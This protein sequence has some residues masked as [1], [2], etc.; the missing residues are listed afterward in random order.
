L[1]RDLL[2]L[3]ETVVNVDAAAVGISSKEWKSVSSNEAVNDVRNVMK[4]NHFDVIPITEGRAIKG[5]FKTST[6]NSYSSIRRHPI[7][8]RDIIPMRSHIAHVIKG[9]ASKDRR[10]YFLGHEHRVVGL[11]TVADL[12]KRPV[13][14]YL[15]NLLCELELRLSKFITSSGI[16]D[17]ELQAI[18]F[19]PTLK[20]KHVPVR[21]RIQSDVTA[22]KDLPFVEYMNLSDMTDILTA[23]G[24][25]PK[26]GYPVK[27]EFVVAFRLISKLR[28]AV[29]HP[30]SSFPDEVDSPPAIWRVIESVEGVLFELAGA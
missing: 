14:T 23:K 9:F 24:L 22:G 18:V 28:N 25:H 11:I 13:K 6:W 4:A 30:V 1:S 10:F 29:A 26:L 2:F 17:S 21:R 19:G 27:S 3:R 7:T 15:F 16:S 8:D 5:Y 20:D 12:N